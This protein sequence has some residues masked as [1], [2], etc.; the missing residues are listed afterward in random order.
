[1][2]LTEGRDLL[3][4]PIPKFHVARG[5][6][7]SRDDLK[8]LTV[9]SAQKEEV[10]VSGDVRKVCRKDRKGST[11]RV[12]Q[13]RRRANT[14]VRGEDC[15]VSDDSCLAQ[16]DVR[17][18]S[19]A[20]DLIIVLTPRIFSKMSQ[21]PSFG[22]EQEAVQV[23]LGHA[24]ARFDSLPSKRYWRHSR[25][26]KLAF[27]QPKAGPPRRQQLWAKKKY[28]SRSVKREEKRRREKT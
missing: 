23:E 7:I 2:S 27:A 9:E 20:R 13:L 3:L 19:H 15:R 21:G 28:C 14:R 8:V 17:V 24:E 25:E 18:R 16:L 22:G 4:A 26:L 12:C 11:N 5:K 10:I 1:M 6:K